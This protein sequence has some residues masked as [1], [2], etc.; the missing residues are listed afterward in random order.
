MLGYSFLVEYI[1]KKGKEN[2]AADALS[3][4]LEA[5]DTSMSQSVDEDVVQQASLFLI[6]FPYPTWLAILKDSYKVDDEYQQ[7]FSNL[8][9]YSSSSIGFSLK[10]DI[11]LYKERVFLSSTSPLKS[12]V[13]KHV[14]NNPLGG[15]SS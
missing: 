3:K 2:K 4:I 1:Y 6:S 15:H 5:S 10:N 13:L 11:I 14:H 12:L 9:D 7:L 8:A